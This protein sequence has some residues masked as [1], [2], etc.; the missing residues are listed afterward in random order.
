MERYYYVYVLQS[1]KD[2]EF[3]VGYSH[4]IQGRVEE[5]NK[6]KVPSTRLRLPMKLVYWEGCINQQDAT[7]REKYLKTAWGKRYIKNRIKRYLT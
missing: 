7:Q 5:H 1:I 2:G 3:Y 6:G 4:N